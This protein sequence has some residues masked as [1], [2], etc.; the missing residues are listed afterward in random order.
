[1]ANY[2]K[3]FNFRNGVQV[4]NDNFVIN[5]NGLV[6]IGTSIPREFLDVYGNSNVTGLTSTGTLAV[7]GTSDFSDTLNVGS[8]ISLNESSGIIT[9]TKF[10]G[11]ASG[12]QN[13]FAISTTGWIAQ[14][15]GLHTFRS[16]GIGTT[17]PESFLQ[18]EGNP[19][20]STGVV[21]G[22]GNI[23][24]SG[25]VTANS[26]TLVNSLSVGSDLSITGV[27]TLS[28][29]V[30][31]GVD[32]SVGGNLNV[33][34]V[35]T[36][37]KNIDLPDSSDASDGRVRFGAS[38]DM[39]LF[40]F[41]GANFIDVTN[42]LSIRGPGVGVTISIKPSSNE[43]GIKIVPDGSV[44]LYYDNS[45][46]FETTSSG[47]T[48]NG[49]LIANGL[50]GVLNSSSA[51]ITNSVITDATITNIVGTSISATHVNAGIS[52]FSTLKVD[53]LEQPKIDVVGNNAAISIGQVVGGGNSSSTLTFDSATLRINNYD[54]GG[55]ELNLH[56][57]SGAGSTESF[58]VKY[59]NEKQFEVTHDGKVGINRDGA[60]LTHELEVGGD[61]YVDNDAKIVGVLTVAPGTPF[62]MTFGDGSAIPFPSGQNFQTITGISTLNYLNIRETITASGISTLTVDGFE[63]H[64]GLKL[65]NCDAFIAN[66]KVGIG[67]TIAGEQGEQLYVEGDI[68][69]TGELIAK[70]RIALT[71][72]TLSTDPRGDI[73]TP[74]EYSIAVPTLDFGNFQI[75]SGASSFISQNILLV[76]DGGTQVA[77]YGF[78]D[79]GV[80]PTSTLPEGN[81]YLTT[82]GVNTFFARS[83]FDIGVAS[84]S[85][86]SYFILPSLTEDEISVVSNLWQNPTGFGTVYAKKVTP[87]GLVPGALVYNSTTDEIQVRNT[88]SSFRNLSGFGTS[89][90]WQDVTAIRALDTD[91]TNTTGNPIQVQVTPIA[92]GNM[93]G[94]FLVGGVGIA[95]CQITPSG[96]G[97]SYP[98]SVIVPSGSTYKVKD[99][100]N[101][102]YVVDKW[103][104]LR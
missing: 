95:S 99:G 61:L 46:K 55:I 83:I 75:K 90:S 36:F 93:F 21:I 54:T 12:L 85:M 73:P 63:R 94:T 34:G 82:V 33:T 71:D 81:K 60:F 50:D 51:T 53:K 28:G 64:I 14:G 66:G 3:S 4:D 37:S 48:I 16:I 38:S 13:I 96:G 20:T 5:A 103:F 101:G 24:A 22:S 86:N 45:K 79:M 70:E 91:Y 89:N 2:R 41:N 10:V 40:H 80:I 15:V 77:G 76:P 30:D 56:E 18:I 27:S 98:F 26:L 23:K 29:N 102:N 49:T 59:D 69:L 67:T 104:E 58:R 17:N 11:D 62:Q 9:A 8:N 7:V 31:L 74:T 88:A 78:T 39:M 87:A 32:L 68:G 19:D 84:T 97:G 25:I 72:T 44:E 6:G 43:E 47:A 92:A 52:T 100:G 1:M 57:G 35:S 42:P 65:E